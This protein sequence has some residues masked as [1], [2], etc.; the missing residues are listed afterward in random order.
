MTEAGAV[1]RRRGAA[2][3]ETARRAILKAAS[4]LFATRGY[5][6]LTIEGIAAEAGV[7]K[8]TI[9]RWWPSKGSV[10]AEALLEGELLPGHFEVPATGDVRADLTAWLEDLSRFVDDPGNAPFIRSLVTAAAENAD[11]GARLDEALGGSE[12]TTRVEDAVASGEIWARTPVQEVVD[13]LV[14]AV[15][16]RALRRVPATPD[17][18]ERFVHLLLR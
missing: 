14:G 13:A 10:V 3:S 15:V 16:T 12:L 9:Y 8:Q 2:R 1:P 5:D 7:A 17:T 6:H 4:S 11:I 18:A